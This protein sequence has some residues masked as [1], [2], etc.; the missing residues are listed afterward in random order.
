MCGSSYVNNT[1]AGSLPPSLAALNLGI[2]SPYL[3]YKALQIALVEWQQQNPLPP[4]LV[5]PVCPFF[6]IVDLTLDDA[7]S[8]AFYAPDTD[9]LSSTYSPHLSLGD[10]WET[11]NAYT[12]FGLSALD[13]LDPCFPGCS[14]TCPPGLSTPSPSPSFLTPAYT[15]WAELLAIVL[16]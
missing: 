15:G 5:P 14:R 4:P 1:Y 12:G 9:P 16:V 6:L 10:I 3:G 11:W 8:T 7:S 13:I 2:P